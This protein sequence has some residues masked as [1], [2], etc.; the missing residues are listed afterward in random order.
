[1]TIHRNFGRTYLQKLE[2]V[3]QLVRLAYR[4]RGGAETKRQVLQMAMNDGSSA[5]HRRRLGVNDVGVL[6]GVL[7]QKHLG[8]SIIIPGQLRERVGLNEHRLEEEEMPIERT[9]GSKARQLG[10]EPIQ[11]RTW[12]VP[13]VGVTNFGVG[14]DAVRDIQTAMDRFF[15]QS[16]A[17]MPKAIQHK[18]QKM[19]QALLDGQRRIVPKSHLLEQR[20]ASSSQLF[21]LLRNQSRIFREIANPIPTFPAM[22]EASTIPRILGTQLQRTTTF[23]LLRHARRRFVGS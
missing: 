18:I 19:G 23:P 13:Y 3:R 12:L 5:N 8:K 6:A 22:S 1:M 11:D 15:E 16:R 21:A 7:V 4:R 10:P 14:D 20:R 2:P 9:I 17:L